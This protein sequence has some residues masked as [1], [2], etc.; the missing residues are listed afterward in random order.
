[1]SLVEALDV[2]LCVFLGHVARYERW[3]ARLRRWEPVQFAFP[4]GPG[5]RTVCRR[6]GKRLP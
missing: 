5:Y 6:C 2:V 4:V 3:N 1:M